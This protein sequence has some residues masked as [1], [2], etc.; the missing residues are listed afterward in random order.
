MRILNQS[1]RIAEGVRDRRN[2]D[3]VAHILSRRH[4]G[5]TSRDEVVDGALD[6]GN[7][8]VGNHPRVQ[9]D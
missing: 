2:L 8:P 9:P 1:H 7:T 5:G 3:A 4:D 6:V